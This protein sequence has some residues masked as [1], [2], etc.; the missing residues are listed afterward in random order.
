MS[1]RDD[2]DKSSFWKTINSKVVYETPWVRVKEDNVK[3]PYGNDTIYSYIERQDFVSAVVLDENDNLY[4]VGQYRYPI[5]DYTWE[6]IQ[7]GVEKGETSLDTVKREVREEAGIIAESYEEIFSDFIAG[8]S[9]TNAKG[10]IFLVRGIKKEVPPFFPPQPLRDGLFPER[11]TEKAA[12][13]PK[14][15]R[16]FSV[17]KDQ[18]PY[19]I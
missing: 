8:G 12:R 19:L 13:L 3:D 4:L 16:R 9:L 6:V 14:E 7:G 2:I 11:T 1:L 5:K 10:N 17:G 15:A 18:I